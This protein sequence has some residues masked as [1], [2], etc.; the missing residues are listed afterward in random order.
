MREILI[1]QIP[2]TERPECASKRPPKVEDNVKW[3]LVKN[4][5]WETQLKN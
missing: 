3:D 5:I 1:K 4:K 2:K